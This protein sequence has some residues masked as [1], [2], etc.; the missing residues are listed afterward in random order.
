MDKP[1][2][3]TISYSSILPLLSSMQR[4]SI[5]RL[6]KQFQIR[7]I[8][9]KATSIGDTLKV[10]TEIQNTLG[11]DA[12]IRID[13]N[14]AFSAEQAIGL[15][16]EIEAAGLSISSLEQ[17]VPKEDLEGMKEVEKATGLP[18]IAD[19]S[20]CSKDDL[21]RIIAK[22]SCKGLNVRLSKCGGLLNCKDMV[23]C[24]RNAGLFCQLGCHVGETSI[25]YAAGRQLAAICGPFR[26]TEGCYSKF[27]LK[28]DIVLN[29]LEFGLEGKTTIPTDPGLGVKIKESALRRYCHPVAEIY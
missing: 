11:A 17:P 24:A 16:R 25:L 26:Y 27:L 28:E 1:A 14:G 5:L 4:K 22:R 2:T 9:T 13:A 29:P 20:F 6:T 12:D 7:Q 18:T 23:E 3:D 15:A 21:Q 19:E 8:K 10:V